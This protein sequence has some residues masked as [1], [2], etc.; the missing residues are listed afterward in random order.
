M[1]ELMGM[2]LL[3]SSPCSLSPHLCSLLQSFRSALRLFSSRLNI[4]WTLLPW[5][6]TPGRSWGFYPFYSDLYI[7][8]VVCTECPIN[9]R[10]QLNTCTSNSLMFV[11]V[12]LIFQREAGFGLYRDRVGHNRLWLSVHSC[13]WH[14]ALC[15]QP[16]QE[17]VI[18]QDRYTFLFSTLLLTKLLLFFIVF[19][20]C[21]CV[22][23]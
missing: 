23:F 18:V 8:M 22:C 19:L 3:L 7:D 5:A 14:D 10:I 17:W 21:C 16:P 2:W 4:E 1:T 11:C 20:H 13:C 9:H 6:S 15:R 12:F